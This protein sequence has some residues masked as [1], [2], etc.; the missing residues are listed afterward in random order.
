V[1]KMPLRS[2]SAIAA[3]L[4]ISLGLGLSACSTSGE[5][6][7]R[8]LY[9]VRQPVVERHNFTLDVAA[10][11]GG[12]TIPEQQRVAE[13]FETLDLGY[14]DRVAIDGA[15]GGDAVREDVA[16]IA[17]RHGVLLAEGA[18]V[19]EGYVDPGMVR[20]V[21]TRSSA[22][23]PGGPDGSGRMASNL[24]NSTS[25]GFGCAVNSNLAAMVADPEHLLH[26][27]EGTG[28]TVVMSSTKAIQT[29]REQDPT[30]KAGLPEI[31]SQSAGGGSGGSGGN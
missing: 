20:V 2:N 26:G 22:H 25:D 27:A 6:A 31:S 23:V 17:A 11:A 21:V 18:P 9:S 3:A 12:L 24:D 10:G 4:V 13:W 7:N 29:Y 1:I 19:T 16:K 28:E 5:P 14:G 30:G 8:S 15:I